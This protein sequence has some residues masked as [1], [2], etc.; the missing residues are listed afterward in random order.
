MIYP[1]LKFHEKSLVLVVKSYIY[2]VYIILHIILNHHIC[3]YMSYIYI[4]SVD[5]PY[6]SPLFH[7]ISLGNLAQGLAM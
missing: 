3:Q 4:Y 2:T 6:V 7:D 5:V 1:H